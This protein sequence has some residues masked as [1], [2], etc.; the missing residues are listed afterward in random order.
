MRWGLRDV[1]G[2]WL[3][4]KR[5]GKVRF[6]VEGGTLLYFASIYILRILSIL[7]SRLL[8]SSVQPVESLMR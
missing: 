3:V 7:F 8:G 6:S 5:W 4:V 2:F 1:G